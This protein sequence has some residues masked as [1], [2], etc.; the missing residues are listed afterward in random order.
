MDNN[1][2]RIFKS[3]TAGWSWHQRPLAVHYK[4]KKDKTYIGVIDKK[5]NILILSYDHNTK[6]YKKNRLYTYIKNETG[7]GDTD[8]HNSPTV[9]IRSS[10]KRVLVFWTGHGSEHIYYTISSNPEDISDF[11]PVKTFGDFEKYTY[12]Q[13]VEL[14]DEGKIYLF[15]R[16][17]HETI[18]GIR[19]WDVYI[20]NDSGETFQHNGVPLWYSNDVSAPYTEIFSNGKDTIWF[21]RSD[22]MSGY[23]SY[24]RKNVYFCYYKDGAFYRANHKK[25]VDWSDL[26]VI[27][28]EQFDLVFDSDK[29]G[30]FAYA[31]D[32]GVDSEGNPAILFTTLTSKDDDN[33]IYMYAYWNGEEWSYNKITDGGDDICGLDVITQPAYEGGITFNHKNINEVV[34]GREEPPGSKKFQI[35]LWKTKD[36]GKTWYKEKVISNNCSSVKKQFRPYIPYNYHQEIKYLWLG[37]TYNHFTSWDTGLYAASE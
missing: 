17:N 1:E 8:D 2:G 7:G 19:V 25:I 21:T 26:P 31:K 23:T 11:G 5:A 27:N 12:T 22:W 30:L 35:E 37:G 32:I 3:I 28:K 14:V 29:T 16:R 33:N 10:D 4:G 9:L 6:E 34:L 20:S 24:V 36:K 18:S 13:P 15:C